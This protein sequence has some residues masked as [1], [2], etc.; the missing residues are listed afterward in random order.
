M[1]TTIGTTN[2]SARHDW[3]HQQLALLPAG[4]RLLDAGAGMQQYRKD[5]GHLEYV[6]QDFAQYDGVGD[7]KGGQINQWSNDGLDIVS[8]ITKIPQPNGAFDAI[9]CTEV[10]EH[11]PDP[12]EALRELSR[13]LRPGGTILL[14]APFISNTHFSPYHFCTGFSRHFYETH[15][16]RLDLDIQS[17]EF[18]GD[19]FA[20][21]AQEVRRVPWVADKYCNNEKPGIIY[22]LSSAL[23]LR[24]L[25]R[26]ARQDTGS[27]EY[28]SF[29]LHVVATK[30]QPNTPS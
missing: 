11:L 25:D 8:D 19:Y 2:E 5:C 7:G 23:I 16:P 26:L 6:S 18:N 17:I 15:L 14:T 9:L 28:L 24:V 29:G 20:S 4:V 13:L 1:P 12:L 21:L 10:L 30:R 3:V 22:K 27:E